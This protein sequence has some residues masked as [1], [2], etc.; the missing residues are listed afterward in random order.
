MT[1]L[2]TPESHPDHDFV[3]K[4]FR[5]W[6]KGVVYHCDSYDPS[7]GYWMT[8]VTTSEENPNPQRTNVSERAIG[9][10]YHR[11]KDSQLALLTLNV[12]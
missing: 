12:E 8:P 11:L 10:T 7:C 3:G 9:R 1:K 6:L 4:Y 2:L 5:G